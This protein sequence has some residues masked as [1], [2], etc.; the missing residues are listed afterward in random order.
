MLKFDLEHNNINGC[1]KNSN[2]RYGFRNAIISGMLLT[3]IFL[4]SGCAKTVDCEVEELHAHTY[5]NKNSFDKY[6]ESEKSFIGRWSRTHDFV[7]FNEET[8]KLIEFENRNK[9]FRIS[10]NKEKIK[11]ITALHG[12]FFEYRYSYTWLQPIA[13]VRPLGKRFS[14]S[15]V[16]VPQTGYSWTKNAHH[17]NLTGEFREVSY[18][19][20]GYN[21]IKNENG[22]YEIIESEKIENIEDLYKEYNYIKEDFYK[23]VY[24]DNKDLE[25][26][27]E[28]G[29]EE[30]KKLSKK[31]RAEYEKQLEEQQVTTESVKKKIKDINSLK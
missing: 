27:Y 10:L 6:V 13:Q 14:I 9:L 1:L 5:V 15:N 8:K 29:P 21:I 22:E 17:D 31:Q 2:T 4:F 16:Y 18:V 11:D 23:L 20:C 26:D 25:V 30:D 24:S 28:D 7:L 3:N 19:Y 12:T